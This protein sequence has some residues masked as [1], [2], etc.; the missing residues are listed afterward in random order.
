[1]RT[2]TC[3][4]TITIT[5]ERAARADLR[6]QIARLDRAL[7]HAP[8]ASGTAARP[9]LL[10]LAELEAQRDALAAELARQHEAAEAEHEAQRAARA[11]LEAMLADPPAHRFERIRLADLGEP[12]CGAY[13]VRPRLGLVGMLAGWWHVKVSSGCPLAAAHARS[14]LRQSPA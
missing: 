11:R 14:H 10:T 6:A 12:G 4:I 9:R 8:G 2:L 1:M 3:P 5:D 13:A 7:T